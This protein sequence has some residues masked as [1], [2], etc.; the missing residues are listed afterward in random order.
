MLMG[1]AQISSSTFGAGRAAR[2]RL[3]QQTRSRLRALQRPPGP[4]LRAVAWVAILPLQAHQV[5]LSEGARIS[6]ESTGTGDAGNITI[7]V[8]DTFLS[9]N[10]MVTTAA[11]RADGGTIQ[12]T[13]G[14]LLR[15][16]DS[17]ITAEVVGGTDRGRQHHDRPAICCVAE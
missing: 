5:R 4:R 10:S 14:N 1:G 13:A 15:L 6:A 3:R 7:T 8:G 9:Q 12:I 16:P 11:T 17:A 2:S